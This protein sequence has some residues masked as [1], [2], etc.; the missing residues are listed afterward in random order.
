MVEVGNCPLLDNSRHRLMQDF[1]YLCY[2][3]CRDQMHNL[4]S[5]HRMSGCRRIRYFGLV[6]YSYLNNLRFL[7]G[8][9]R[10]ELN[11][12]VMGRR[13]S[14]MERHSSERERH[15]SGMEQHSFVMG[16]RSSGMERHSFVMGRHSFAMALNN[17]VMEQHS[18]EIG[19]HSR[20]MVLNM[21]VNRMIV[22][23]SL[24]WRPTMW[25]C[26]NRNCIVDCMIQIQHHFHR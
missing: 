3:S 4:M 8:L 13:S 2:C 26:P 11:S 20:V 15:S 25:L 7:R 5:H 19:Q 1:G 24:K 6:D 14:G 17:F 18:S 16:H 12:F 21:I 9:Y 23:V 22:S 10:F